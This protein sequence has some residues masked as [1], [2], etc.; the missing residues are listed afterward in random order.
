M[1]ERA[2]VYDLRGGQHRH[3]DGERVPEM[4]RKRVKGGGVAC[5]PP[6]PPTMR[7]RIKSGAEM[8]ARDVAT[9]HPTVKRLRA[10][11]ERRIQGA[12]SSSLRGLRSER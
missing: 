1:D 11:I 10:K 6:R 5:E 12:V 3:D 4:R 7:Q 9:E 2:P 8:T